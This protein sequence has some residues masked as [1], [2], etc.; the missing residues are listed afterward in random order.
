MHVAVIG[1]GFVGVVSAAVFASFGNDVTGLDIDQ[2]KIDSLEKSSVPFFEPGLEELLQEAQAAGNLSFTTDYEVAIPPADIVIVAVGTPSNSDGSANLDYVYAAC[3]SLAPHLS[4]HAVVVVKSTVPPGTF[5]ALK[6]HIDAHADV[7]YALCSVPEFLREGS[8]VADTLE[9][10]R[11]VIGGEE[12][13]AIKKLVDLHKPIPAPTVVV[14]AE[15]AQLSK[16][17]ANAY[18]AT[19]ITFINQIAN[20]CEAVG[21]DVQDVIE[22][23]GYDA[24]IGHHYWYPGLGYGGSCFPKDVKELAHFA[25]K[26]GDVAPLFAAISSINQERPRKILDRISQKVDGWSDKKVA[27]LG[28]SFKPHTDDLR[29]APSTFLI[30]QLLAAGATVVGF[31]PKAASHARSVLPVHDQFSITESLDEACSEADIIMAVIEWPEIIEHDYAPYRREG[32]QQWFIDLR[33]QFS[34]EDLQALGYDYS[35]IGR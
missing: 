10:G 31:D 9:A 11:V 35:G 22:A 14:S 3:A 16:Y 28:L 26:H 30:P 25:E 27:F 6:Q 5:T 8:A 24:R 2:K 20:V 32:V 1:T 21:A 17:A 4:E 18:L 15:A 34:A 29:E 19:R 12:E 23:F 13:W 33:N 7:R